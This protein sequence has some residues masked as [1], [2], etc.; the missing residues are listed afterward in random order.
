MT[1]FRDLAS[2]V[3]TTSLKVLGEDVQWTPPAG[4]PQTVRGIFESEA[5]VTDEMGD[6]LI[7]TPQ[8][9]LWVDLTALTTPP[10]S[11]GGGVFVVDSKS[12]APDRVEPGTFG[13]AEIW[14]HDAA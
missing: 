1:E 12:Y 6:G 9:R 8:P 14:L 2:G 4:S 10:T 7:L 5:L 13:L 3:N 11:G